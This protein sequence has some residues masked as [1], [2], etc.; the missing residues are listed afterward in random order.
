MLE[1]LN[2]IDTRLFLFL[3]DKHTEFFDSVMWWISEKESW[4]PLY[5]IIIIYIIYKLRWKSIL[6]LLSISILITLSDQI[7]VHLFKEVFQRLRPCHNAQIAE[8]IHIVNNHCGGKYSFVSSHA[9]NSFSLAIFLTYLFNNKYFTICAL[10]WATIIS[11]S[12]IY[13]GLHYPGDVLAGA[14]LGIVLG[15]GLIELWIKII[16]PIVKKYS[17]KNE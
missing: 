14:L 8:Y 15:I 11:Y 2:N 17:N 9:S 3:N 5:L 13:L 16:E 6:L 10:C 4:Y 12:R 7:S 1:V